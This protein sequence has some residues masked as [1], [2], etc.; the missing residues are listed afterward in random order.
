VST[1]LP[2]KWVLSKEAR[3]GVM[4]VWLEILR[5]PPAPSLPAWTH[6]RLE[7]G[8]PLIDPSLEDICGQLE[9]SGTY[10]QARRERQERHGEEPVDDSAVESE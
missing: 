4:R 2:S 10:Q 6:L 5:E 7:S 8:T 1:D 3:E 9:V